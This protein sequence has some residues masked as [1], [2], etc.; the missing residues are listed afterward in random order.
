MA[1]AET[2][3]FA[4]R[5]MFINAFAPTVGASPMKRTLVSE[6]AFW[7]AAVPIDVTLFGMVME[8]SDVAPSKAELPID[9]TLFGMVMEVSARELT[10]IA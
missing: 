2:I 5:P 1:E 8:V 6:V 9:V 4:P 10:K 3:A 7:K